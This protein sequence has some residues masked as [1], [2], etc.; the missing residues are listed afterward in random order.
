[1]P[2]HP[3]PKNFRTYEEERRRLAFHHRQREPRGTGL[4]IPFG[5]PLCLG[6]KRNSWKRAAATQLGLAS[7]AQ[8][9]IARG[10]SLHATACRLKVRS[11]STVITRANPWATPCATERS[12]RVS[13]TCPPLGLS[14]RSGRG[15]T[16][17]ARQRIFERT[18]CHGNN[19][20]R[21]QLMGGKPA[22]ATALVVRA[23]ASVLYRLGAW[24][25]VHV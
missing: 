10:R 17:H 9:R 2:L 3:A 24:D 25:T 14:P 15:R 21:K 18:F 12:V 20:S 11:G 19:G 7:S 4:G 22:R 13:R 23:S 16:G 1:M 5:P 6:G 8:G